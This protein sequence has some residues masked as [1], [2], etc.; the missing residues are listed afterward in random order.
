MLLAPL[1]YLACGGVTGE[2]ATYGQVG[3][4][5]WTRRAR[6]ARPTLTRLAGSAIGEPTYRASAGDLVHGDHTGGGH[7]G[8]LGE[9]GIRAAEGEREHGE[10]GE[11]R[12]HAV[13]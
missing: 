4:G 11:R 8:V 1:V 12:L 7:F 6:K 2:R 9:T 13:V 5:G 10:S 3:S